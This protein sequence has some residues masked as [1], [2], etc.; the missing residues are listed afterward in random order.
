M[1]RGTAGIGPAACL[2]ASMAKR[3]VRKNER[4]STRGIGETY[5]VSHS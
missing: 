3:A 5:A 1:N 2:A 4:L